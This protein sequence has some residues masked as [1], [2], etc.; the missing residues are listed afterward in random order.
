[1]YIENLQK[2]V[3]WLYDIDSALI[4]G[5][6]Y[7]GGAGYNASFNRMWINMYYL[8]SATDHPFYFPGHVSENTTLTPLKYLYYSTLIVSFIGVVQAMGS[9]FVMSFFPKE[10]SLTP[11]NL[12]TVNF[13]GVQAAHTANVG[14][15]LI[16][17][18]A[19]RDIAPVFKQLSRRYNFYT[20]DNF[21]K[22]LSHSLAMV[23]LGVGSYIMSIIL[24]KQTPAY[25]KISSFIANTLVPFNLSM[26]Y[27]IPLLCLTL[28]LVDMAVNI[29]KNDYAIVDIS[30]NNDSV[31]QGAI[32]KFNLIAN[33]CHLRYGCAALNLGLTYG[34]IL[35]PLDSVLLTTMLEVVGNLGYSLYNEG[36]SL[37]N[38]T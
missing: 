29:Y 11:T 31:E 15:H 5:S 37:S 22:Y 24:A 16:G 18:A 8:Y 17:E 34:Q 33:R 9:F 27:K 26:H 4:S 23:G 28:G 35:Q 6:R 12:T 25:Y 13:T 7:I 36:I 19:V 10:R 30:L 3:S 2:A 21:Q 14:Q 1:M 32:R 38:Y 20:I